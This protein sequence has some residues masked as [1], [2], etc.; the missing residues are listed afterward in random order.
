MSEKRVMINILE[1]LPDDI[2]MDE[3]LET[4]NLIHELKNRI[5]NADEEDFTT[6]EELKKEIKTW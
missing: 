1:K 2:S 5:N 4:L 6:H 3:L